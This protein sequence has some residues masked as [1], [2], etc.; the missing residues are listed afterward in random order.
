MLIELTNGK[1]FRLWFRYAGVGNRHGHRT[2]GLTTCHIAPAAPEGVPAVAQ[3][4]GEAWCS[5]KDNP[6]RI[7]GRK[8]A[9]AR[10][11]KAAGLSYDERRQVWAQLA[12]KGMRLAP[13]K[14]LP[15]L[16]RLLTTKEVAHELA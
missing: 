9:C 11:L 4:K 8:V 16:M 10:A 6:S 14:L 15:A 7:I 12:A 1:K 3:W 5:P 13:R 2:I